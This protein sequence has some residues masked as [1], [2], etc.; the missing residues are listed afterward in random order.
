M[1]RYHPSITF[2]VVSVGF[3]MLLMLF[4]PWQMDSLIGK[5]AATRRRILKAIAQDRGDR[6]DVYGLAESVIL[7][8]TRDD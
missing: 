6:V 7:A 8:E 1:A 5:R 2:E 4:T 3:P